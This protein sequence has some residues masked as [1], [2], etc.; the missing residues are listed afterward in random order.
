MIFIFAALEFF[1]R[2]VYFLNFSFLTE[3]SVIRLTHL[4]ISFDR[5][6]TG[7]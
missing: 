5:L 1:L 2:S 6:I 3:L 7:E 4:I